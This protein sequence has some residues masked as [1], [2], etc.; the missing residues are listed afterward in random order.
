MSLIQI[1]RQRHGR[2]PTQMVNMAAPIHLFYRLERIDQLWGSWRQFIK[3]R[4]DF[5]S[6][7]K[8]QFL[9]A[10]SSNFSSSTLFHQ[11]TPPRQLEPFVSF[12]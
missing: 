12:A 9:Q 1:A 5:L 3:P 10:V 4:P 6:K 2:V 11:E 8:L 7:V